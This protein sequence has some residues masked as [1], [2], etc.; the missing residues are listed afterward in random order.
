VGTGSALQRDT[1]LTS[2]VR[3]LGNLESGKL[4]GSAS[5]KLAKTDLSK[6]LLSNS[7]ASDWEFAFGDARSVMHRMTYER[8]VRL[9]RFPSLYRR[10]SSDNGNFSRPVGNK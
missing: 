6:F 10:T 4:G 8:E 7:S 1:G 9:N 3:A 2:H 5:K